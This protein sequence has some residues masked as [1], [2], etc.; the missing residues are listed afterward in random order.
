MNHKLR[1]FHFFVVQS[2]RLKCSVVNSGLNFNLGYWLKKKNNFEVNLRCA[3]V[4]AIKVAW[5]YIGEG[6]RMNLVGR[7]VWK[8]LLW[9]IVNCSQCQAVLKFPPPG[10]QVSQHFCSLSE[11]QEVD[12]ISSPCMPVWTCVLFPTVKPVYRMSVPL[13]FSPLHCS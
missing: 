12:P 8:Q 11:E 6:K 2:I 4:D 13:F 9:H 7:T 10:L 5:M 3:C 1:D